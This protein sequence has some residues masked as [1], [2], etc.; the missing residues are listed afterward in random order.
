MTSKN[1]FQIRSEVLEL[2]KEYMDK[3]TAMNIEYAEKMKALNEIKL[4]EY[5]KAF[6]PY[7]FE[8]M[9]TKAQEFY[10]FVSNKDK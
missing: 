4:E 5:T 8:E 7:T 1:P 9:M 6:K 3:Q 2:A 10:S